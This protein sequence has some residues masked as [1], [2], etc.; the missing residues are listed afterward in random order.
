MSSNFLSLNPSKTEFH[1]FGIPQQLSKLNNSTTHLL[2]NVIL[3]PVDSARNLGVIFDKNMSFAQHIS[4]ISK[5]CFLN[6]R[7]LRRIC[8]TIDHTT[9]CTIATFLIHSKID[10]CNSLLL[11]LPATQTNRLQRV[12]N[13]AAGAVTKTH[14]FHNITPILKFLNWLKINE[15]IKYKVLSLTYKSFITGQPSYLRSLLSFP[16]H[17][18]T[19]SSSLITLVALLSPLVLK[20][21]NIS[22]YQSAPVLRNNLPSHIRQ[23]AHHVTPSPI[24]N[25]SVSDLSTSLVLKKLKTHLFH[26][27]IPFLLSLYSPMQTQDWYLSGIDQASSFHLTFRYHS[28][29]FFML[30]D[31]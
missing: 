6:M 3:S 18:C 26:S 4:S 16:S 25:S 31:L 20:I 9:A 29:Q 24:S 21:A 14:K 11:N 15:R 10:Y 1:I 19:W 8:N 30:F 12:L 5:S 17:R 2:S 27:L 7:D 28:R 23:V 22:F 13:S